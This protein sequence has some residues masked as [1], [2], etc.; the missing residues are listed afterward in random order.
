MWSRLREQTRWSACSRCPSA[1]ASEGDVC[2]RWSCSSSTS[3]LHTSWLGV[4]RLLAPEQP[5]AASKPCLLAE[6]VQA[7]IQREHEFKFVAVQP[8]TLEGESIPDVRAVSCALTPGPW[9]YGA[10]SIVGCIMLLACRLLP[11][12]SDSQSWPARISASSCPAQVICAKW[13]DD[14]Y[15]ARRCPPEEWAQRWSP[16]GIESVWQ[17]DVLPCRVYLRQLGDG[18]GTAWGAWPCG[19]A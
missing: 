4:E 16:Y 11:Q 13:N 19:I 7:F 15:K 3:R 14:A 9:L 17:D 1:Q 8:H 18:A 2:F 10:C 6:A 5:Q 12:C